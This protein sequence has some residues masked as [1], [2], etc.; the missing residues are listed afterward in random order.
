MLTAPLLLRAKCLSALALSTQK[1]LASPWSGTKE[2]R[3]GG[4][5][6]F[7][8]YLNGGNSQVLTGDQISLLYLVDPLFLPLGFSF[9]LL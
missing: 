7:V 5:G 2:S 8:V 1:H 9:V 4:G 3:G 6:S